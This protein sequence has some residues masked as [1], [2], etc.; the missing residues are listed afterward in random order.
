MPISED[1]DDLLPPATAEELA[2]NFKAWFR[3]CSPEE[4]EED[5]ADL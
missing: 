1:E 2:A 5:D 3:P 4:L